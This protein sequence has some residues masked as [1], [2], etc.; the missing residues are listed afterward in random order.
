MQSRYGKIALLHHVG[1]GNLG[2]DTTLDTII[3]NIR[4]RSPNAVMAAFTANPEDTKQ[5]HQLPSYPIRRTPW[6]WYQPAN[7]ELTPKSPTKTQP[8]KYRFLFFL[9][10]LA[11]A[12]LFRFPKA[13]YSE[14]SFLIASRR[15]LSSYEVLIISG[16]G[17][18][19][20]WG[21]PW[22]FL[23]TLLK[24]VLLAKSARLKCLFLNVGA[25]PLTQPL[26]KLFARWALAAADYV[27]FRDDQSRMLASQIGFKGN[28]QVFSDCVYIR[29][30]PA[31]KTVTQG[32]PA[33]LTAGIAPMPYC[34]PRVDPAERNLVVYQ[35]FI[36]KLAIFSSSLVRNSY[37][38]TMFGTDV[39]V[40]PLA[41]KDLQLSL[42]HQHDLATSDYQSVSTVDELLARMS[43]LDY[44]VTCRFHGVVLAHLL[45]KP[46]LALSH[47]PKVTTLMNDLGLSKYCV[48][49]R[50]FDPVVLV[51][52]FAS[53]VAETDEIK[54]RMALILGK[55][56]SRLMTQFDELFLS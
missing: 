44:V 8:R 18:L 51:D 24:W 23:Y 9:P 48:D 4:R 22:S 30:V 49:I 13:L 39:G 50:T 2:D 25:G 20:E 14:G 32:H 35:A 10:R 41:I 54:G 36:D 52:K 53:L 34:D 15:I 6:G 17:Q 40:D 47:H 28:G 43:A 21:G 31:P 5:R 29:E 46:V 12:L 37:L 1:S 42:L 45:N 11:Y 55:Y 56:R 19:T 7:P 33:Q 38:L 16:G 3:Q 27:S 26:S